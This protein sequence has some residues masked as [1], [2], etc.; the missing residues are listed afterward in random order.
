MPRE[1]HPGMGIAVAERTILRKKANGELESWDDVARR[2]AFGNSLLH[3]E[4][5]GARINYDYENLYQ[6]I[7]NGTILMSG[8]H[9]QHGDENQPTRN[10]E[11]FSNCAT[12]PTSFL[13][14]YLLLNGSG[15]GRCYDD[16]LMLVDWDNAPTVRCVLDDHHQDFDFSAH[17]SARDAK[18]KYGNGKTF[19]GLMFRIPEKVGPRLWRF[20]KMPLSKKFIT[21]K[22]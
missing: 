2:V 9:L 19:F 10:Q 20:G 13:L 5:N 8:R 17:E 14:F 21:T 16:D 12:A 3:T 6:H 22:C 4:G 1:I 18:H 7:S 11:I 15:V